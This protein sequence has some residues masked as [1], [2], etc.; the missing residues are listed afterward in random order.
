MGPR[1]AVILHVAGRQRFIAREVRRSLGHRNSEG[2]GKVAAPDLPFPVQP[3]LNDP[4]PP[5]GA[6]TQ[7]VSPT[8]WFPM[9]RYLSPFSPIIAR[10]DTSRNW[11]V[12]RSQSA[13]TF[14]EREN[15]REKRPIRRLSFSIGI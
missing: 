1:R 14:P 5:L 13:R 10:D 4:Q 11:T 2:L 9:A 8:S 15:C 7:A 6:P 3:V 12:N